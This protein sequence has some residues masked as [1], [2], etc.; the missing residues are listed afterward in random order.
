[1]GSGPSMLLIN[2]RRCTR[3]ESRGLWPV[4]AGAPSAV[5]AEV[6][7]A[8]TRSRIP[9]RDSLSLLGIPASS[10]YRWKRERA[11]EQEPRAAVKP[12]QAYPQQKAAV[13]ATAMLDHHDAEL[14]VKTV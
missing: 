7:L 12:V 5:I 2:S 11:W 13:K 6:E 14:M 1:M 3:C 10:Y 9:T 8:R 4:A